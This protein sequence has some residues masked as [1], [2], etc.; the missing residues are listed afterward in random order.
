MAQVGFMVLFTDVE[1]GWTQARIAGLPGVITA[2]P[3]RA[4]AARMLADALAEYLLSL[5]NADDSP[6]SGGD[7]D[8]GTVTIDIQVL[9][10]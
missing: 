9:G 7:L 5:A 3:S 2:A 8:A 4:V 1:G 6:F 10:G